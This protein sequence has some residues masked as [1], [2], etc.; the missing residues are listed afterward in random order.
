MNELVNFARQQLG[1]HSAEDE[2]ASIAMPS[3]GECPKAPNW[4]DR[5]RQ[6]ARVTDGLLPDDP[7][8]NPLLSVLAD[9]DR[10]YQSGDV[11]AFMKAAERVRR[12]MCFV[13]GATVRW[14][15]AMNHRQATLG[16]AVIEHV[17]YDGANLYVFVIWRGIERWV[18]E[19]IITKI[20]RPKP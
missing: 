1:R 10:H 11:A 19:T 18:S 14:E 7:R 9:C 13:P 12:L 20:E 15:G 4:L 17:H 8:L 2:Q 3:P 16:P 5:W 6:L